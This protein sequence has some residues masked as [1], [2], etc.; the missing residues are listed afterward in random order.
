MRNC[1]WTEKVSLLID[2]ELAADA[3]QT[4]ETHLEDCFACRMA[5]EDFLLLR[6]RINSY[7][8]EVSLIAQREALRNILAAGSAEDSAAPYAPVPST[9]ERRPRFAGLFALPQLNPGL[10]AASALLLVCVVAGLLMLR[11]ERR[12]AEVAVNPQTKS[13]PQAAPAASPEHGRQ[14]DAQGNTNPGVAEPAASPSREEVVKIKPR[15]PGVSDIAKGP[16]P[17]GAGSTN[18]DKYRP[19][20]ATDIGVARAEV[21]NAEDARLPREVVDVPFVIPPRVDVEAREFAE[22]EVASVNVDGL[23]APA[24]SGLSTARH[25]EQAQNLLRSFRNASTTGSDDLAYERGRSQELLYQ[26]ILL[27]RQAARGGKPEV[28]STLTQLEPILLDIANLPD[29]PA[30]ADVRAI[31]NRM[32]RKNIVAMLQVATRD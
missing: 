8:P 4:V 26:N 10:V 9:S 15:S 24:P 23:A 5:R 31:K 6:Q 2:G 18:T 32:E 1:D 28:E 12:P 11:G 30:G 3:A 29:K 21:A 20:G 7:R 16:Q 27:R 19:K 17:K 14:N 25:A 13:T 22:A